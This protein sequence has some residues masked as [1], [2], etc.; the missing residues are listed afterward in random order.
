VL[1]F[2]AGLKADLWNRRARLGFAVFSY[3]VDDQQLT[4]VGGQ[5]NFNT[6]I[7]ADQT[8]GQGFELDFDAYLTDDLLV[9]LGLSYNDTEIDDPDLA[10]Q[11]CGGGCTVLDPAG[12]IAGTV[13]IDGNS[14][15][16]A[17]KWVA[18][19]TARWGFPLG[20][21]REIY[22]YTDWAYRD[23]VNFFLYES[24][25]FRGGSLLE[26]GLRVAY[27]WDYGSYE[28][29]LFGRNITDELELVGGID[30]NNLTGF[31]NEPRIW[32]VEFKAEF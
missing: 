6:L 7:N 17:P 28:V 29:A 3:T 4:A 11:P 25:E 16:N 5:T 8:D 31:V 32:G 14:L 9:T 18:N 22:V 27:A 10:I 15:P 24:E 30:F 19:L 21:G 2:E 13:L 20:D 26:G 1:S 23:D 12:P